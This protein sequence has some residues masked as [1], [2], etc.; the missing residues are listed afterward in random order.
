MDSWQF[1]DLVLPPASG[2]W[3]AVATPSSKGIR[4]KKRQSAA[5]LHAEI[6]RAVSSD[7]DVFLVL[8][9]FPEKTVV[10]D[11]KPGFKYQSNVRSLGAYF[12]DLDCGPTPNKFASKQEALLAFQDWLGKTKLPLPSAIVDSGGGIH[13]YWGIG[14]NLAP[15]T[16]VHRAKQLITACRVHGFKADPVVTI[17][18]SRFLRM[19][20]SFNH[21]H[22]P[23]RP[24]K[25]I[26]G[27]GLHVAVD[28][29]EHALDTLNLI[30]PAPAALGPAGQ[31]ND[32]LT[33]YQN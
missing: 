20:G 22:N 26:G 7:Q 8:A 6:E 12:L 19:P 3:F 24:C 10:V 27:T 16:W 4:F 32:D 14:A 21:K 9:E 30:V 18:S 29:F 23:P 5:Q 17:D 31:L 1:L 2:G 25:I 28:A 11:G 15:D 33:A 13:I